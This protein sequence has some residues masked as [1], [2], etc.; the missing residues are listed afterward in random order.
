MVCSFFKNEKLITRI[1]GPIFNFL[2]MKSGLRITGKKQ[3]V[4]T[5]KKIIIRNGV[6]H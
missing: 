1:T 3:V 4:K 5:R 6:E 2:Q